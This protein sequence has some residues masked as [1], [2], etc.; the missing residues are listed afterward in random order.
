MYD[1]TMIGCQ[2]NIFDTNIEG[3]PDDR[4]IKNSA[5]RSL[6]QHGYYVNVLTEEN[7]LEKYKTLRNRYCS[8]RFEALPYVFHQLCILMFWMAEAGQID[9]G[10]KRN[11]KKISYHAMLLT[12]ITCCAYNNQ[13]ATGS[14]LTRDTGYIR[15]YCNG[16]MD[17]V[18][19][20][21]HVILPNQNRRPNC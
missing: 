15:F 8:F 12:G 5:R 9:P 21:I 16:L 4:S 7:G 14:T 6:A 19:E 11:A 10:Y 2:N 18:E 17:L 1:G 3:I 13:V 20:Y